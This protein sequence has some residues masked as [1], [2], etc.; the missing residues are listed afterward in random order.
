MGATA[1]D[2]TLSGAE[3][4]NITAT[5]LTL[6][7]ASNGSITV[8]GITAANSNNISGAV[9]LNA[10][11]DNASVTFATAAS[12]FNVLSVNADDGITIAANITTDV[13]AMTLEGDI[14]NAADGN[15]DISIAGGV[16]LTSAGSMTLDAT[17]GGILP[18]AAVTMNANNGVTI[19]DDLTDTSFR[20]SD[21]QCR[22]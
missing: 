18:D 11:A 3:L 21:Y 16:I 12:T 7:D 10:T 8:N 19:N 2:Y 15:D 6:G 5:G 4:Q 1:G 20:H 22:R 9:V 17:T 14:D 13:G